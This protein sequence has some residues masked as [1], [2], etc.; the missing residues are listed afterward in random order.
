MPRS[1]RIW[2][3]D[4]RAKLKSMAGKVPVWQIAAELHRSAGATAAEACK[5]GL[6]LRTQPTRPMEIKRWPEIVT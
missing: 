1:R 3:E 6:S 5:M 4:D 2:T